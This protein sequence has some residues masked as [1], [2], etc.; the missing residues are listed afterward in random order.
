MPRV[1][2]EKM[3]RW[4]EEWRDKRSNPLGDG[5]AADG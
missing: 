3:D 4:Y 1:W 5:E 2:L